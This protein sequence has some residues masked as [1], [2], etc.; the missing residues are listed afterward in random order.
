MARRRLQEPALNTLDR[1]VLIF[2]RDRLTLWLVGAAAC[3]VSLTLLIYYAISRD[4]TRTVAAPSAFHMVRMPPAPPA[5]AAAS[6]SAKSTPCRSARQGAQS[7]VR[8]FP[9]PRRYASGKTR[10]RKVRAQR[11]AGPF[12]HASRHDPSCSASCMDRFHTP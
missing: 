11:T 4:A 10:S 12:S 6:P 5:P 8:A 9:Q 3:I 2:S 1:F 7:V